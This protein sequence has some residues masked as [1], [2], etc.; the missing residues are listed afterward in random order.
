MEM[1]GKFQ[2]IIFQNTFLDNNSFKKPADERPIQKDVNIS[3]PVEIGMNLP[4]ICPFCD[5]TDVSEQIQVGNSAE[6]HSYLKF[7]KVWVCKEHSRYKTLISKK[8]CSFVLILFLL[9]FLFIFIYGILAVICIFVAIVYFLCSIIRDLR[10]HELELK[11]FRFEFLPSRSVIHT[12]SKEW[13]ISFAKLNPD[14]TIVENVE[15]FSLKHVPFRKWIFRVLGLFAASMVLGIL[16]IFARIIILTWFFEGMAIGAII[17]FG[18]IM[19]YIDLIKIPNARNDFY[20]GNQTAE[21]PVNTALNSWYTCLICKRAISEDQFTKYFHRC[22]DCYQVFKKHNYRKLF[23]NGTGS[24]VV[25]VF[26]YIIS[27]SPLFPSNIRGMFQIVSIIVVLLAI[28]DLAISFIWR[29]KN[30]TARGI[31]GKLD[32]LQHL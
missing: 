27:L 7:I 20:F 4:K 10:N 26:L 16:F 29:F 31:P 22:T 25:C 18:G 24:L 14:S 17:A 2:R 30:P 6:S 1:P 9:S 21:K 19:I 3:K 28:F 11:M 23:I 12:T 13:A 15:P 8:L 32:N 5:S